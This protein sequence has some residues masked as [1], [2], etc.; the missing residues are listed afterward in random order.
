MVDRRLQAALFAL[1]L[2][3]SA[4]LAWEWRAMPQLGL[5]HDDGIYLVTGKSLAEGHGLRIESLPWQP[6]QTKYPPLF[7]A[8][9]AAIWKFGPPF[10]ENLKLATLAAW[11]ML[12]VSLFAVRKLFQRFGFEKWEL[13]LLTLAVGMH[14]LMCLLSTVLM[15]DLLFLGL[16]IGCLLVAERSL[17]PR[18]HAWLA[19]VS[20]LMAG[21]AYLTRTAALPI[22]VTATV[23][24][25]MRKQA[26]R[27][28]LFLA[29]MLPPVAGWQA[30]ASAHMMPARDPALMYYTNYLGS[31]LATVHLDNL[32]RVLWYNL[33]TL[34]SELARLVV[35]DSPILQNRY[36]ERLIAAMAIA[37]VVRLVRRSG[38]IQYPSAAL[39]FALL[40]LGYFYTADE[41]LALPLY[42]LALMGFA[43]EVK[44]LCRQVRM[45]WNRRKFPDRLLAAPIA[46]ALGALLVFTAA[47][48]IVG[49]A[50]FL[51]ALYTRCQSTLAAHRAAYEWLKTQTPREASVYA[52]DDPLLYLY[53][54]RR[55]FGL[56]MPSG[57][58]YGA[59]PEGEADRFARAV[60]G[61]ACRHG[62][63][64]LLLTT[65]DFYR[66]GR[67]GL[68]LETAAHDLHL[69]QEFAAGAAAVYRCLPERRAGSSTA[70]PVDIRGFSDL[71]PALLEHHRGYAVP[72][73]AVGRV[74]AQ[75][76]EILGA[77][78]KGGWSG[79]RRRNRAVR[80]DRARAEE[81]WNRGRII[82]AVDFEA[83]QLRGD[84]I[85]LGQLH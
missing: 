24:F 57:R 70:E 62:L 81:G 40:L 32:P 76:L 55:A 78:Q 46:V 28:V 54:G 30:W 12:P 63:D 34:L 31:Q 4:L 6:F 19:L 44:N 75:E 22:V 50:V 41:R 52:Y 15:T 29:G 14:P 1:A 8:L 35:F 72:V 68:P 27:G 59:D 38:Q 66:E 83:G 61:N 21:L 82:D 7:P 51:P 20:G 25:V 80:G 48:Y 74:G 13:S 17:D 64:Y 58:I 37:G 23:C 5:H 77:G 11:C 9:I 65:E 26:R 56:T 49:D 10:P 45:S 3:P 71:S 73:L 43:T 33:D 18:E 42:P 16:F 79:E 2:V 39:G 53:T 36:L 67:A 85:A 84:A 69:R 60:P 47:T